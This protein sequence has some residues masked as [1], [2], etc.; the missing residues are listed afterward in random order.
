[1]RKL[2]DDMAAHIDSTG[3]KIG[4]DDNLR[5]PPDPT[6]VKDELIDLNMSPE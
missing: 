4:D 2:Y 6:T 1:M 5:P 3:I